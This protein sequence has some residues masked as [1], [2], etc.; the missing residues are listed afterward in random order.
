MI[1]VMSDLDLYIITL[2]KNIRIMKRV[3]RDTKKEFTW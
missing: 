2:F 3:G 1:L